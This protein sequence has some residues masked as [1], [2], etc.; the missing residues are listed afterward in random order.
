MPLHPAGRIDGQKIPDF[1]VARP[2]DPT[3]INAELIHLVVEIK[4]DSLHPSDGV[5]QLR[6][7]MVR[8]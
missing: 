7:Y 6:E 2:V 1:L 8:C 5:G 4:R 3:K